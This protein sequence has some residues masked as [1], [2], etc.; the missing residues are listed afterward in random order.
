MINEG[1][2]WVLGEI[3]A[4]RGPA[5]GVASSISYD[6]LVP[7]PAGQTLYEN[8]QPSQ[9]RPSDTVEIIAA[10]PGQP[11]IVVRIR[12]ITRFWISEGLASTPCS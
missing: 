6:V 5:V 4:R 7:G 8:V 12:G 2:P 11:V 3:A 10:R 9:E 1:Y